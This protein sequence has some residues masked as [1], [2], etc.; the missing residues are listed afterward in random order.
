MLY[1]SQ[2]CFHW[3]KT[4]Q[5]ISKWPTKKTHLPAPPII[6]I[7]LQKLHGLVLWSALWSV[8]LIDT[9]DIGVAQPIWL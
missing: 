9:K 6:N 2:G 4:K 7:F 8:E 3:K 5:K 1:E